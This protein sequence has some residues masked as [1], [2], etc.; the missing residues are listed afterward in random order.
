MSPNDRVIEKLCEEFN[1]TE[2]L[3]AQTNLRLVLKLGSK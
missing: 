2:K 3:F 1:A